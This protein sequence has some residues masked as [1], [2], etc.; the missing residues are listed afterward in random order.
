MKRKSFKSVL[1]IA[2]VIMMSLGMAVTSYADDREQVIKDFVKE[3]VRKDGNR[4]VYSNNTLKDNL[5][6]RADDKHTVAVVLDDGETVLFYD[7]G[8]ADVIY[9]QAKKFAENKRVGEKVGDITS[10]MNLEADTSAAAMM[11]SGFKPILELGIGII[12]VLI[13]FGMTVFSSFDICYI[14]FP[15]FRNKMEDARQSGN[16]A[17][18]KKTSSG[19]TSLRWVTDDAQYAVQQGTIESGKSPWTFYFKKRIASYIFLGITV[20]ILLTGNISVLTDI[21]INVVSGVVNIISTLAS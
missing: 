16:S 11:L 3:N 21:A 12:V 20:F 19:E 8:K 4:L 2:L 5:K 9:D 17:L 18:T 1:I 15:V 6:D 14:A 7:P 10:N 13:T